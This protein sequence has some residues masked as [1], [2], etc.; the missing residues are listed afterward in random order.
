[1]RLL[2]F[3]VPLDACRVINLIRS[4][5]LREER[6]DGG[7]GGGDDDDGVTSWL[8]LWLLTLPLPLLSPPPL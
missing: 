3:R 7:G 8:W 4:S 2:G 6:D 1:M 5:S